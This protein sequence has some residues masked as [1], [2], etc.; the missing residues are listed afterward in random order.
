MESKLNVAGVVEESVTDG[1]GIRYVIF[2]QG[3]PHA[4]EGCHNPQTHPFEG[5]TVRDTDKLFEQMVQNPLLKGVT[6][7]GGEPFCQPVSLALLA[8]RLHEQ[9]RLNIITYTGYTFEELLQNCDAAVR[10]LL[11]QTD[12]LIDG[13]F[14]LGKR[15]IS[16]RFRGST[17]QRVIDV[18]KSLTVG[19]AVLLN[20]DD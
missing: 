14:E 7:S 3:C 6:F 5:G 10:S 9:T 16:L 1:P 18:K 12:I 8:K 15:D 19:K 11:E 2:V 17:N 13:R 4:C 20:F